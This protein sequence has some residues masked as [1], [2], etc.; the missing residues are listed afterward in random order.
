MEFY[1]SKNNVIDKRQLDTLNVYSSG[2]C[3]F[4]VGYKL[5]EK[6]PNTELFLVI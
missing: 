2:F 4:G 1:K 6:C 3:F 5:R